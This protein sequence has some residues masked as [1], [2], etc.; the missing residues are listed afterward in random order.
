MRH[1]RCQLYN[2][3]PEPC[4]E[5]LHPSL[6]VYMCDIAELCLETLRSF[7]EL[8]ELIRVALCLPPLVFQILWRIFSY[9]RGHET[10]ITP[11]TGKD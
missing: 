9:E 11:H 3:R 6:N 5:A 8:V 2:L 10:Q 7:L 4:E 1:R